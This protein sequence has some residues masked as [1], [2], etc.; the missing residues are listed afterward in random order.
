MANI[1]GLAGNDFQSGD[2]DP[3]NLNDVLN[4]NWSSGDDTMFG[5][6][7]NDTYRVNSAGDVAAENVGAGYDTILSRAA[8][9]DMSTNAVQ[10]EAITLDN[11]PTQL[12]ILPGGGFGLIPAAV[13]AV[14]NALNNVMNGNDRDNTLSGM[15]GN[16]SLYGN[17][18]N[19]T[20]NGGNGNDYLNGGSGNDTLIGGAGNDTLFGGTGNDSMNG[21]LGND[22]Y[23][24]DAAGDTI[25][26]EVA[27]FGGTDQVYSSISHTLGATIEN[28]TLTGTAVTGTGNA[29]AN[30]LVGTASAN[31][32]TGNDGNDTLRGG[33]GNDSL[34][35]G[36]GNDVLNGETGLDTLT[37]GLGA[38]QFT[39]TTS[40]AAN[41]D[42]MTDFSHADDTIVL[43]NALDLGMVGALNPGLKGLSFGGNVVGN[44]LSAGWY[45]EGV[46]STGA[47]LG[48][49]GIYVDTLAGEIYYDPT[50]NL[51]G[52]NLL[53]GRVNFA[54]AA[55]LDN[56]DF[57]LGA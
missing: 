3:L 31:T 38:D 6:L 26:G 12:V 49:S 24:V 36:N 19:D 30:V 50:S 56:T 37:G 27:V 45:F 34:S 17:N 1:N 18:G 51:A 25:V 33:A 28:L 43:G 2:T 8:S 21:G 47:G 22:T 4:F 16:D 54:I 44:T 29:L 20:L 53:I 52:D 46:G 23:Y 11:T 13:S 35:G 40:G 39:F 10:V 41:A 5:G 42:T 55:T 9:F 7:G 14:G 32:L 48:L 57:I 15:D